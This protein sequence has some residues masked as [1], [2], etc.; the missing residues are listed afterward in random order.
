MP[1]KFKCG[2]K[3][4]VLYITVVKSGEIVRRTLEETE[5]VRDIT[6]T[7]QT[8]KWF[9]DRINVSEEDLVVQ[10]DMPLGIVED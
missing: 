6:Y 5:N 1:F 3:V 2:Q 9:H 4:K 7:V 8:G 10:Q